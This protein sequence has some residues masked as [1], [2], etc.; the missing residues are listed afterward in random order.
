MRTRQIRS[1]RRSRQIQRNRSRRRT[2]SRKGQSR[3]RRRVYRGRS[4]R[5]RHLV[6]GMRA[7]A[8]A[9]KKKLTKTDIKTD[10]GEQE[11]ADALEAVKTAERI[12]REAV[13]E[14]DKKGARDN[15]KKAKQAAGPLWAPKMTQAQAEEE[16]QKKYDEGNLEPVQA[17]DWEDYLRKKEVSP[18]PIYDVDAVVLS[19]A[20]G[21]AAGRA[22]EAAQHR[23]RIRK[24]K[25]VGSD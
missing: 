25:A 7:A 2:Q 1:R 8:A 10:G 13:S 18:V 14:K 19:N 6:G 5:R 17:K 12:L 21:R 16:M 24:A 20:F 11:R 3:K 23:D 4:S 9:V 15:L 22:R